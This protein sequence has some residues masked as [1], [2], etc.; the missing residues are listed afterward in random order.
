[1]PID[2]SRL[3]MVKHRGDVVIAQCPV[4]ASAGGDKGG[5]HLK[6]Y[7]DGKFACVVNPGASGRSHR[8]EVY[9]MAGMDDKTRPERSWS[10][11]RA[12]VRVYG[13]NPYP[14]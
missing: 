11:I 10:E 8:K 14:D 4:C 5:I 7:S 9:R 2:I 1:M 13:R 12:R 3:A 6:V